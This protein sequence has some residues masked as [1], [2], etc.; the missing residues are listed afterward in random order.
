M[1]T[2]NNLMKTT[3]SKDFLTCHSYKDNVIKNIYLETALKSDI[4]LDYHRLNY[5]MIKENRK[6]LGKGVGFRNVLDLWDMN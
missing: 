3:F 6:T 4:L 2:L 5:G 1:L